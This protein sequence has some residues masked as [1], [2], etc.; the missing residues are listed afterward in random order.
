MILLLMI[1]APFM[2]K[3]Q[4]KY[5]Q[6]TVQ[7]GAT[8]SA[9][10]GIYKVPFKD[11]DT[12]FKF[13]LGGQASLDF[14]LFRR[15]SVGFGFI[16]QQQQLHISNYQYTSNGQTITENPTF[17]VSASALYIRGFFHHLELFE[18]TDGKLDLYG[19]MHQNFIWWQSNHTSN[20]PNFFT[21]SENIPDLPSLVGGLRYY[22]TETIGVYIEG[23]F[24]GAY[25]VALGVSARFNGRD[26]FLKG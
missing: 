19:G 15:L 18:N 11:Y 10:R 26:K 9:W 22:P 8:Y 12:K 5:G 14:A 17:V 4:N 20:D 7:G 13:T 2:A 21:L 6:V 16:N 24:P 25:T 1:L 23:S 3:S